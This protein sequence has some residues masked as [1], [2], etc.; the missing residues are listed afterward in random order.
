MISNKA[1]CFVFQNLLEVVKK[2]SAFIGK[3][4]S[5]EGLEKLCDHLSFSNMKNNKMINFSLDSKNSEKGQHYYDK[6]FQFIRSGKKQAWGEYFY[7][8]LNARANKWIEAHLKNTDLKFPFIDIY[9]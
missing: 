8:E 6:E 1:F 3:S 4:Y 7:P 5:E 2:V 9:A